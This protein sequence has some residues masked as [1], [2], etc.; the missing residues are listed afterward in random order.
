MRKF[1]F[2]LSIAI[3]SQSLAGESVSQLLL[4]TEINRAG[5]PIVGHQKVT[6]VVNV[7]DRAKVLRTESFFEELVT[8]E[9]YRLG[10]AGE[11][12]DR[13]WLSKFKRQAL[14]LR[15][16]TNPKLV[17]D[18][19]N[20]VRS[21]GGYETN[22]TASLIEYRSKENSELFKPTLTWSKHEVQSAQSRD[23]ANDNTIRAIQRA[24]KEAQAPVRKAKKLPS[25]PASSLQVVSTGSKNVTST[26]S[27]RWI[28]P[29]RK[30]GRLFSGVSLGTPALLNLHLGYWGTRTFP[31]VVN[32]SGMYFDA[33]HRGAELDIGWAFGNSGNFKHGIVGSLAWLPVETVST[34]THTDQI[35]RTAAIENIS[36]QAVVPFVGAG[37]LFDWQEFRL[38]VGAALPTSGSG[39]VR[40]L[41]QFGFL[42]TINW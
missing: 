24:I 36:E 22:T 15:D 10:L 16:V 40:M 20:S 8:T 34:I 7:D 3:A 25:V 5:G 1:A 39:P 35:G 30:R 28:D 23:E 32:L 17:F 9:A 19:E 14:S 41:I 18:I 6:I 13:N 37:Y 26:Y 31:I 4:Q 21:D 38:Q 2:V 12:A 42:P 11:V 29:D 27:A 33:R